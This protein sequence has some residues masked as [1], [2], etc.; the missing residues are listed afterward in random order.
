MNK[1]EPSQVSYG[2]VLRM[3]KWLMGKS[4]SRPQRTVRRCCREINRKLGNVARRKEEFL[5]EAVKK[6]TWD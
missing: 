3:I 1:D 4:C 6:W 5:L 2:A